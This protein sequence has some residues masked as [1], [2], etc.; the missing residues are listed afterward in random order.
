MVSVETRDGA[1]GG[2]RPRARAIWLHQ[3]AAIRRQSCNLQSSPPALPTQPQPTSA[4]W[5]SRLAVALY[6]ADVGP[7]SAAASGSAA[8]GT[9]DGGGACLGGTACLVI[10]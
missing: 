7:P 9:C 4:P 1:A 10:V 2:Q 8:G 6:C 5:H 3:D